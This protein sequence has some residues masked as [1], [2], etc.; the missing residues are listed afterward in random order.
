[1]QLPRPL[2]GPPSTLGP[3]PPSVASAA[4]ATVATAA[5]GARPPLGPLGGGAR[6][7]ARRPR[8]VQVL[9]AGAQLSPR[10]RVQKILWT[11]SWLTRFPR[12]LLRPC[13]S[14]PRSPRTGAA[15]AARAAAAA[16]GHSSSSLSPPLSALVVRDR[17]RHPGASPRPAPAT[18]S[19]LARARGRR[20]RSGLGLG[21]EA[22][23]PREAAAGP[24]CG[25]S[26][27]RTPAGFSNVHRGQL[28]VAARAGAADVGGGRA[29]PPEASLCGPGRNTG[30]RRSSWRQHRVERERR[31]RCSLSAARAAALLDRVREH[32]S[33]REHARRRPLAARERARVT[34]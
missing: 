3:K 4:V 25:T 16:S 10:R 30:S 34:S 7:R 17:G 27:W 13:P 5:P 26:H 9:A 18:G 20:A 21:R 28:T 8:T 32:R 29:A 14:P 31:A 1:M 2:D 15:A 23:A 19:G 22:T 11:R 24:P 33:D 12:L 6:P